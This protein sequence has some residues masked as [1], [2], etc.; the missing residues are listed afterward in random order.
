MKLFEV[1]SISTYPLL[2]A[3]SPLAVSLDDELLVDDDRDCD[4]DGDDVA[5]TVGSGALVVALVTLIE[6]GFV[7]TGTACGTLPLGFETY[8]MVGADVDVN[9]SGML[10]CAVPFSASTAIF[11]NPF[12][13]IKEREAINNLTV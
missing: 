2:A 8:S 3:L 12:C 7:S 4:C 9:T 11:C 10:A 5:V 6:I 13:R 1:K